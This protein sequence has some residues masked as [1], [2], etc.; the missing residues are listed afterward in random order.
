MIS[1]FKIV[2]SI[3]DLLEIILRGVIIILEE[4]EFLLVQIEFSII[5]GIWFLTT[6]LFLILLVSLSITL[7]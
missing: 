7:V 5:C 6:L 3:L 2:L 4:I 1:F